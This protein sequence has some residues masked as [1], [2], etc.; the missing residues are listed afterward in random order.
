MKTKTPMYLLLLVTSTLLT[1]TSTNTMFMWMMLE[2]NMLT[3]IPLIQANNSTTETE[4]SIKYLI[5]QSFG[6]GLFMT[7]ILL[8]TAKYSNIVAT[9]ALTLKLG[10]VPLHSWFPAVMQSINP[11]TALVL[12]TWQKV[13][14]ILLLTTPHLAYTPIIIASATMSALWGSTAG[15]N[16]T[17]LLKL[18]AFSSIS[19]LG[20]LL[21][22]SLYSSLIPTIYLLTYSLTAFPIFFYMKTPM[23]KTYTTTLTPPLNNYMQLTLVINTLSLAGMPPLTM[24]MNK[25]PIISLM[26]QTLLFPLAVLL[27]SA[28][29]SLYFY[30][31]L[32]VMMALNFNSSSQPTNEKPQTTPFIIL[33]ISTLFQLSA[34]PLWL[35]MPIL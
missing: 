23:T 14:P 20:W 33:T 6:S 24:F 7:S 3:F 12:S 17:N 19:H 35:T 21:S 26:A 5:P 29:I 30:A 9:T 27:A 22:A 2:L 34:L 11:M 8:M 1:I 16:Q 31:S 4:A 25:L 32:S 10:G 28:A 15:L 18:M 13:A